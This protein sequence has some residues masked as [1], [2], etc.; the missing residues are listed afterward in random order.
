[1]SNHDVIIADTACKYF[2]NHNRRFS[3]F[4]NAVC[5]E[6]K[7]II[8]DDCLVPWQSEETTVISQDETLIDI[9][10]YRDSIKKADIHGCYSIIALESQSYVDYAMALRIPLYDLLNYYNQFKNA[11]ETESKR[12]LM[13]TATIVFYVGEG[14]WYGAKSLKEMMQEIPEEME[15]YIN[16]WEL[17]FVD[18]KEIDEGLI[19]DEETRN[20]IEAV[21]RSYQLKKGTKIEGIKLSKDA[22]IVAGA[23]T[24]NEWLVEKARQMKER[25]EIDMCEALERY[26]RETFDEGKAEGEAKGRIEGKAEGEAIGKRNMI[27]LQLRKKIGQL[28][29]TMIE[30]IQN[31]STEKIDILAM[32]I[33]DIESEDDIL[34]I[35]H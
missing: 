3:S 22:A 29:H 4:F 25:E 8:Q 6:G 11:L 17:I 28:S 35:I 23:I 27:I 5:F 34:E 18:I 14:K 30:R 16:D 26:T 20:M 33:F 12:K 2:F 31:T 9:K 13:P 10:R 32:N 7:D 24:G 19:K 15:K 1:M 21:K